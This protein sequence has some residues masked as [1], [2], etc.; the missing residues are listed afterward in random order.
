MDI[1]TSASDFSMKIELRLPPAPESEME[2][3]KAWQEPVKMLT[4]L[5]APA[6]LNPI[7]LEKRVYQGSSGD[8]YPLP[9]IDR[10]ATEPVIKAWKAIHL[11]NPYIRLMILPEIGGRIH[12]GLDKTNGYDF[13]YRQNV[14]KPALVGLAGPWISGGFEFNWPQH[15][16]PAT[17]MPVETDIERHHDGSVT[18]WCSDYDPATGMK[19]MHGVCLHPDRAIVELK[20]RLYNGTESVQTFLWWAN[21]GAKVRENYQSFFP[22]DATHVADTQGDFFGGYDHAAD[23]GFIHLANHHI[24]PGKKQWTW[25]NHAFGCDWDRCLTDADGPYVELMAGVYTENQPDFSYLAPGETKTFNQYWFPLRKCSAP[26]AANLDAAI[27]LDAS[28][29]QARLAVCVTRELTDATVSLRY[30]GKMLAEWERELTVEFGFQAAVSLP[31]DCDTTQLTLELW[32]G[33][34]RPLAYTSSRFTEKPAPPTAVVP[35]PPESIASSEELFLTGLHLE[36]YRHA[37]RS[38]EPYWRESLKRDK[39]DIR[40]NHALAKLHL[41]RGEYALAESHIRAAI[42]RATSLNG[43]PYDGEVFYTLGLVLRHLGRLD[44]AYAAF[45]KS[46]WNA[47][48][49]GA[50][51]HAIAEIDALRGD[52]AK[53]IEHLRL[54]LHA[55]TDNLNARNLCT[56]LLRQTGSNDAADDL[57]A[58][59]CD[60]DQLDVWS[61]YLDGADLPKVSRQLLSLGLLIE[62][63]GQ[64]EDAIEVFTK[65]I[66][67]PAD[68]FIPL[69]HIAAARCNASLRN[70]E[71]AEHHMTAAVDASSDYCFPSALDHLD[72]LQYALTL[73]PDSSRFHYYLGN[74]L[75]HFKRHQEAILH[76]ERSVTLNASY[77]QVWRNLAI[78]SFNIRRNSAAAIQAF[79][80]ARAC[81]PLDARLLYE[82]DQL[83][84]R[85]K[86]A[87]ERRLEELL[88]HPHLVDSRDDLTVELASLFNQLQH[89]EDALCVLLSRQFQPWEGGEGLV[90]SQFT[91]AKLG[92]GQAALR[93]HRPEEALSHFQGVLNPPPS[94]GQA[95]HPLA[96]T[97]HI[98]YWIG[99]ACEAMGDEARSAKS[100]LRSAP[101]RTDFQTMAVQP[102]SEMTYWSGLSMRRLGYARE[103][104]ELF[105]AM[106]A[107]GK[108]LE[109]QKAKINYF[110]ASLPTLLLF[111]DDLDERQQ[112]R[113]RVV[114]AAALMGLGATAE[115]HKLLDWIATSDPNHLFAM[116]LAEQNQA[117]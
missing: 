89:P 96:N 97:C 112:I 30:A 61:R 100:Y 101:K 37:T 80:R 56:T 15:H 83:R 113:A 98:H 57:L 50:G 91:I 3:V 52:L 24:A 82:S 67:A 43:N 48:W 103:A 47:A 59:T 109:R 102:F 66:A 14:I 9:F 77:A 117:I 74:V 25:G 55:N 108:G 63:A 35:D 22:P 19:G 5:P 29:G 76:W 32:T 10:I 92:L 65:G 40:S 88:A 41:N 51:Y 95:R 20:V 18:V 115:A 84:K 34:D 105:E 68:G 11:E 62:R 16:R 114:Q 72:L 12:V 78:G 85:L 93:Q 60:L 39:G 73:R 26:Q 45:Y 71:L 44:E 54:S 111:E 28:H 87:P 110:A 13:F 99:R 42:T 1:P 70:Q 90:L 75:Y 36:Q 69:L 64:L 38:P 23:A 2:D 4:Y 104:Q 86:F 27:R 33:A 116:S 17:F 81:A 94:L 79:E 7:F 6:D 21:V 53:A 49:H 8:V 46:T 107:Y 31:V 106:L 58:G